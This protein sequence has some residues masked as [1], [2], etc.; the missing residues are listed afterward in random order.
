MILLNKD[1]LEIREEIVINESL[2]HFHRRNYDELNNKYHHRI[3]TGRYV[4]DFFA[5]KSYIEGQMFDVTNFNVR[6]LSALDSE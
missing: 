2:I 5:D 6:V 3:F 4:L 1:N